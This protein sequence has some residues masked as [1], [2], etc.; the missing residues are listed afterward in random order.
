[1]ELPTSRRRDWIS[2]SSLRREEKGEGSGE[3][4]MV[5]RAMPTW[6]FCTDTTKGRW[7]G[8]GGS[9]GGGARAE[10]GM[11]KETDQFVDIAEGLEGKI[12]L[13]ASLSRV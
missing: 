11:G 2:V 7:V 9:E 1:M 12:A 8:G 5:S 4:Q 13:A 6:E 3:E 10:R